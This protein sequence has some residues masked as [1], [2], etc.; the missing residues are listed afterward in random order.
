LTGRPPLAV[1]KPATPAAFISWLR[2]AN[3]GMLDEGNIYCFEYAIERLPSESP[4]IEIGSFCGLS[5]N[6][7]VFYLNKFARINTLITTDKW[8]FEGAENPQALLEGSNIY[9][10]L[11]KQFVKDTYIRNISFFSHDR[12]PYTIEQFSDEFFNMWKENK[13]VTDVLGRQIQLGG[14]ISLAYIDGNHT[15]EYSKRDFENTDKFLEKGGFI[16][17]DDSADGSGWEVCKVV[18]EV[19]QTRRYEL[20]LKNPNYL[21]RK[22]KDV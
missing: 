18:E 22:I 10:E 17:F 19:K 11:Y 1:R 21:F 5:T 2:F 15:Y 8:I 12:L 14:N 20:V 16:L 4:L 7:M 6:L 3:A 9:H 13:T